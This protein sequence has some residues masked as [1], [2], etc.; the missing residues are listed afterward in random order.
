MVDSG[1]SVVIL[2]VS[3]AVIL[4]TIFK[5]AVLIVELF[6]KERQFEINGLKGCISFILSSGLLA[7]IGYCLYHVPY[8]L[9]KGASW[10]MV[11]KMGP[12][13]VKNSVIYISAVI[14]VLYLYFILTSHFIK[15]RYIDF[16]DNGIKYD[17]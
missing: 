4:V 2:C 3:V 14:V 5:I 12:G 11:D 13:Y 15:K 17:K 1:I 7:G 8:I 10:N 9:L 6:K 16:H